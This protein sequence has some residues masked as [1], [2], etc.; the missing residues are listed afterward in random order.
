MVAQNCEIEGDRIFVV[1]VD[2]SARFW[3]ANGATIA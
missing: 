1:F 3:S 2:V